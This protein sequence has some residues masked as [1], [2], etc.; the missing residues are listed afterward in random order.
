MFFLQALYQKAKSLGL[1]PLLKR[2]ELAKTFFAKITALAYLP[3]NL[4]RTQYFA[5]KNEMPVELR[6]SLTRF[7]TYYE[8]YWM[9]TVKPESYSVYG[10]SRRTN[11]LLESYNSRLGHRLEARPAPWDFVGEY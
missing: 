8:T 6:R 9:G 1:R 3:A 7:L 11:N 4:I 2:N 10:L 5:I